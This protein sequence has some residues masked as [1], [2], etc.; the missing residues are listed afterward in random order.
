MK[1]MTKVTMSLA[2]SVLVPV[3]ALA[4]VYCWQPTSSWALF[5]ESTN[6]RIQD[7]STAGVPGADDKIW[8]Y[9]FENTIGDFGNLGFFDLGG[10]DYTVAGFDKGSG[11]KSGYTWHSYYLHLTNGV[12]KIKQIGVGGQEYNK[13]LYVCNSYAVYD[14]ARLEFL[15]GNGNQIFAE[16]GLLDKIEVRNGGEVDLNCDEVTSLALQMSIDAGGKLVFNPD[17]F[18]IYNAVDKFPTTIVNDGTLVAPRGFKWNGTDRWQNKNSNVKTFTVTQRSGTTFIGGDFTKTVEEDYKGGVMK[19]TLAGGTLA[20]SNA[21]SFY[22][23]VSKWG[24]E[25][26]AEMTGSATVDVAENG[27]L[28]MALFTFSD[29]VTLTKAGT[30]TLL[31]TDTPAALA[32]GDGVVSFARALKGT[33]VSAT[34]GV[35]L[36]TKTGNVL[37]SCTGCESVD[38]RLDVSGGQFS[39]GSVVLTSS[40]AEVLAAAAESFNEGT[41]PDG[42]IA[43]VVGDSVKLVAQR[44]ANTFSC[45]GEKLLSDPTAWGGGVVPSGQNVKIAGETTIAVLNGSTPSF[46]SITVVEGATLKL[47]GTSLTVPDG[48]SLEY[49]GRLLVAEDATVSFA[50]LPSCTANE[51]FLPVF[52]VAAGS[53]AQVPDGSVFKNVDVRIRGGSIADAAASASSGLTFG[54]A[55]KGETAY[56]AM[57]AEGGS[58]VVAGNL[59][60]GRN[61]VHPVNGGRVK[62]RGPIMLRDVE[63]LPSSNAY[64]GSDIG[65]PNPADEAF[66]IVFNHTELPIA[67][68]SYFG[69]GAVVRFINESKLVRLGDHPG[70]NARFDIYQLARIVMESGSGLIYPKSSS[71]MYFSPNLDLIEN[72]CA[73]GGGYVA[74]NEITGYYGAFAASNGAWRVTSYPRIPEDKNPY[75]PEGDVHNWTTNAFAAFK[76][77]KIYPESTLYIQSFDDFRG[78]P[79]LDRETVFNNIPI[80]GE[81][82]SLVMTN[83]TPGTAFYAT[84]V[85]GKNTATG[86]LSVAP[87][88]DPTVFYFNDGANWAG[89]VQGDEHIA[90][91]NRVNAQASATVSFGGLDLTGRMVLRYWGASGDHD[92]INLKGRIT[93]SGMIVPMS[94]D[95]VR[96]QPGAVFAL[97]TY[98]ATAEL[99]PAS[100]LKRGW[101]FTTTPIDSDSVMLNVVCDPPGLTITVR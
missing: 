29:A 2:S 95:G 15:S 8:P 37:N 26:A 12:L 6:W 50:S 49:T 20:V 81:N 101:K 96:A 70:T 75:L 99:P 35:L 27:S 88:E 48:I 46:A 43:E 66:E 92:V 34:G 60:E 84:I 82:G 94:Q 47:V 91:T 55:D 1:N 53:V 57:S 36:F 68:T 87:A 18:S 41:L 16:S 80:T 40:D 44:D 59:S 67:R 31:L 69:G 11:Y 4:D 85:N 93:G 5:G 9:G 7:T 79:G 86:R 38:F 64:V 17:K 63:F 56:F 98:P 100:S 3:I 42:A 89:T 13:G 61:F 72:L 97:G 90:F 33:A 25:V 71:P 62:V 23:S 52:E 78:E 21:V 28:D 73:F 65:Y 76:A 14:G 58:I 22:N 39:V 32:I 19:F 54:G 24:N 45:D 77:V 30:G 74:G 83:S 10:G 51:E